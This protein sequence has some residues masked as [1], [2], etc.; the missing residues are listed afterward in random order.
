MT[1]KT[2]LACETGVLGLFAEKITHVH[3]SVDLSWVCIIE[4]S[5]SR[6]SLQ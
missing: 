6:G 1:V 5:H 3:D 4:L 2:W